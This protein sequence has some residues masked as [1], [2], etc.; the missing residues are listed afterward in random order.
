[1]TINCDKVKVYY[2][3]YFDQLGDVSV[4]FLE[5]RTNSLLLY[6]SN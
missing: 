5:K 2:D 3:G 1:M 6:N 4:S